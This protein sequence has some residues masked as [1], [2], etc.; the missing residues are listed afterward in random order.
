M[1]GFIRRAVARVR[2]SGRVGSSLGQRENEAVGFWTFA[3]DRE[4]PQFEGGALDRALK[5]FVRLKEAYGDTFNV[6]VEDLNTEGTPREDGTK[7]A[8]IH[9]KVYVSPRNENIESTLRA[10]GLEYI[11]R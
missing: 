9:I 6:I 8:M 5:E 11:E 3:S 2:R 7:T 4:W 1:F 10:L